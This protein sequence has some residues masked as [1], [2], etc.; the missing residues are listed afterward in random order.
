[1]AEKGFFGK[2]LGVYFSPRE[3]FESIDRKPDWVIP[4]LILSF[5]SAA[6]IIIVAPILRE[7]QVETM[8]ELRD[9]SEEEAR[10]FVEMGAPVQRIAAPVGAFIGTF[11]AALVV[12]AVLLFGGNIIL[13]GQSSFKKV[14]SVYSYTGLGVGLVSLLIKTPLI[15]SKGTMN[16]QTSPA[17][18]LSEEIKESFIYRLL[19]KFDIFTIWQIALI[20]VGLGVIYKFTTKKA[21]TM[22]VSFW[23]LWILI[24]LALVSL[25]RGLR[26]GG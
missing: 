16:I 4:L 22:V 20:S 13:G 18:L 17:V 2:F 1:M 21:A 11:I 7:A 23:I 9:M 24:S 26:L 8:M 6:F 5:L 3:T 19:A 12:S 25:F 15:L 14:L 10:E